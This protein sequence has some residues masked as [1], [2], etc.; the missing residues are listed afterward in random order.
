MSES[1]LAVL[2]NRLD[3][4][5]KSVFQ[6]IPYQYMTLD[7][8]VYCGKPSN[9]WDHLDPKTKF[10]TRRFKYEKRPDVRANNMARACHPC[11]NKKG[12][13]SL[14]LFINGIIQMDII[15][16]RNALA[17][18]GWELSKLLGYK[19]THE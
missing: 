7:P 2:Q 3:A 1:P 15:R 5:N 13:V 12:S 16:K 14:I 9:S 18:L 10:S 4:C 19:I 11:N 6:Y 17:R 8:C